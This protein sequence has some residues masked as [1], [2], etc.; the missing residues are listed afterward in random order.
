[1]HQ[2]RLVSSKFAAGAALAVLAL[3]AAC[4]P[5]YRPVT[6]ASNSPDWATKGSG[7]FKESGNSVFYGVG[8][9][10]GS[11]NPAMQR[12][13]SDERGRGEIAAVMNTYVTRLTKD[14]MASTSAGAMDKTSDEQ[15]TSAVLKN[16]AKATLVGS[17]CVD[18]WKDTDGTMYALCKLDVAE[19]KKKLD[20]AKELDTKMRDFV[21]ANADKAFDELA[22]EEGKR[23]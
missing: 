12:T 11:Q 2:F 10:K 3:T 20:D 16:F 21:R 23:N 7:A 8:I 5:K 13:G 6:Q 17:V 9:Y 4:G 14:Y 18:H 15:H 1:M 19:M 22:A